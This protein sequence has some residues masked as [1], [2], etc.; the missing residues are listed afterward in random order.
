MEDHCAGLYLFS[1]C[2]K[3]EEEKSD[4]VHHGWGRVRVRPPALHPGQWLPPAPANGCQLQEAPH[5]PWWCQQYFSQQVCVRINWRVM[6]KTH[7][8]LLK[9][10]FFILKRIDSINTLLWVHDIENKRAIVCVSLLVQISIFWPWILASSFQFFFSIW[11]IFSWHCMW[12]GPYMYI[13]GKLSSQ[14]EGNGGIY[15]S[16]HV[17]YTEVL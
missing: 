2:W 1:S 9:G 4:C 10:I 7:L 8:F 14:A 13:L 6:W 5:Q 15:G 3:Y 17:I 11:H 12:S 16:L